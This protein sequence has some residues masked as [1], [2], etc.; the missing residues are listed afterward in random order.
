M[1]FQLQSSRRLHEEHQATL[2]LLRRFERALLGHARTF[3][4]APTDTEW[5]P[6]VRTLAG[7]LHHEIADHFQFE[8]EMLFPPLKEAGEADMTEL[9]SEE[10]REIRD[11]VS[12]LM[13]LLHASLVAES[14]HLGWQPMKALGLELCERLN[15][16]VDKEERALIPALEVALDKA[17]DA[18]LI[19]DYVES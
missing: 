17:I 11:V 8:E 18:M 4:P 7:A 15:S 13:P 16:H 5:G 10:H 14:D 9:L 12:A 19:A 3:P 2:D 1:A 6:L